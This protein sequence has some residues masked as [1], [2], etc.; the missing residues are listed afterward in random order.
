MDKVHK[1][2]NSECYTPSS[3]PIRIYFRIKSA[4]IEIRTSAMLLL[5]AT[6]I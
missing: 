5:L 6:R 4:L 3:E 2:Y 1:F